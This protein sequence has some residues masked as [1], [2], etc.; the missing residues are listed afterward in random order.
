MPKSV[1]GDFKNLPESHRR[2]KSVAGDFENLPQICRRSKSVS[3][4]IFI[5]CRSFHSG[6]SLDFLNFG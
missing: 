3:G 5:S 2:S 6:T 1:A 4:D